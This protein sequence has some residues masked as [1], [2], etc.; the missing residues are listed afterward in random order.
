MQSR[1]TG[2]ILRVNLGSLSEIP[3]HLL[4]LLSFACT[5]D[6]P[7]VED[8]SPVI[9]DADGDGFDALDDC[10]DN[11]PAVNPD[12]T[13]IPYDGIDNDCT[14]FTPDDDLD[15]DGFGIDTDCDDADFY[16]NSEREEIAY[17][18]KDD[19]CE[20]STL[21]DDLDGDGYDRDE[22]CADQDASRN[23]DAEEICD[24]IDND[25]DGQL[26]NGSV[27]LQPFYKD[28]DGDGYGYI[29]NS[30]E[31]CLAPEGYVSDPGDCNDNYPEVN[32]AAEE[33]CDLVDN[34]CDGDVDGETAIDRQF[35]YADDD[36][37]GYGNASTGL[38]ACDGP[39][40]YVLDDQDCDDEDA[41]YNPDTIWTVDYDGDGFGDAGYID[42]ACEQPVGYVLDDTDCKDYD[43]NVYPGAVETCD[44][45]DNDCDSSTSE[46]GTVAFL[47]TTSGTLTD[48]TSTWAAGVDKAPVDFKA[49]EPG[50][51]RVCGSSYYA[52][53]T[54]SYDL[55]LIGDGSETSVLDAGRRGSNLRIKGAGTVNIEG[56][57]L[58]RGKSRKGGTLRCEAA[59]DVTGSD[60]VFSDGIGT[61]QGGLI[62]MSD[63]C[64]VTLDDF[65][66]ED[67]WAWEDGGGVYLT[68][69]TLTLS[70]GTVEYC[71]ADDD[72]G[73][74][75]VIGFSDT[76]DVVDS[77]V[78]DMEDVLV[79][80]NT[81]NRGGGLFFNGGSTITCSATSTSVNAGFVGNDADQRGGGVRIST[82]GS[83]QSFTS[84]ICDFGVVDSSS[85]NTPSDI[86]IG[87]T[88]Y[89]YGDD[90]QFVCDDTSCE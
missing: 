41:F 50:S 47:G 68:D 40:G 15:A 86:E 83:N 58:Q 65:L 61:K 13:E 70:N 66:M 59:A 90:A 53:I 14:L 29:G 35:W 6:E 12:Q 10:D 81:A 37:D 38:E 11:D 80:N 60:V 71:E 25:C 18:G 67:G 78:L 34:D 49:S 21:D 23:P 8:T 45:Q 84:D 85:D 30:V 5:K 16:V 2:P 82:T 26:D 75:E 31:A 1:A 22:D 17:N 55:E 51:L 87:S 39:S 19:D 72:G 74:F 89:S 7:V 43:A 79:Q 44:D 32:P 76:Y 9:L 20:P 54:T 69:G 56:L 73:A 24:G 48:L 64:Q 27:D 36:M 33:V 3:V 63:G 62:Y 28:A 52:I 46:D 57:T 4:L 42:F 77:R 88:I